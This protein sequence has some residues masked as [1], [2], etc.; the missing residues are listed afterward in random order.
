MVVMRN[1]VTCWSVF[2]RQSF[3]SI[4]FSGKSACG[5]LSQIS[6]DRTLPTLLVICLFVLSCFLI[7]FGES[8][9]H[10]AL[11]DLEKRSTK[12]PPKNTKESL[13]IL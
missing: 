9:R 1:L 7:C 5:F 13:P 8:R 2:S 6:P 11:A 10:Q 3:S 4:A 12:T